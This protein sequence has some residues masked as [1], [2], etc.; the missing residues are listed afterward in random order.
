MIAGITKHIIFHS[1]GHTNAILLLE[2]GADIYTLSKR[3][4]HKEIRYYY[5]A[6]VN[7]INYLIIDWII[8]KEFPLSEIHFIIRFKKSAG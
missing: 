7:S 3:L 5:L 8:S 6:V 1:A 4:G 2:D